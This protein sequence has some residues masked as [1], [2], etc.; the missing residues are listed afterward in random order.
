MFPV[1]LIVFEKSLKHVNSLSYIYGFRWYP[2][3]SIHP[4]GYMGRGGGC[5]LNFPHEK[6]VNRHDYSHVRTRS[7]IPHSL[8]KDVH[9]AV[10]FFFWEADTILNYF[11][12]YV[13]IFTLVKVWLWKKINVK[14]KH[15]KYLGI[16]S[17]LVSNLTG[18]ANTHA[19]SLFY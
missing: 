5:K 13:A 4:K 19:L 10:D 14:Y 18:L 15:C 9:P 16:S 17:L 1:R 12:Y 2:P 8:L 11:L 6:N 3:S 7:Y